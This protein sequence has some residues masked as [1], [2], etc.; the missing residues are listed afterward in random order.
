MKKRTK[1][2]IATAGV[3]GLFYILS[4]QKKITP[5]VSAKRLSPKEF[6]TTYLP[7]AK[8]DEK[9]TGVPYL[10]TLAQGALESGFGQFAYGNNFFGIKD[11]SKWK[12]DIQKLRTWEAGN[13]G[14]PKKDGITDEIIRIYKPNEVGNRFKSK[15]GYRVRAKFRAYPTAFEGFKDHSNFLRNNKRYSKAFN[16]TN[17]YSFAREI[18]RA[19]YATAPNYEA[20][21]IAQINQAN[22]YV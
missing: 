6:Y 3:L 7:F 16:Y 19:G 15:Y 21:L 2:I 11:S 22:L 18:A 4:Q 12:G 5:S 10:V 17:P 1:Q 9:K 13:T 14:D 8:A 20:S